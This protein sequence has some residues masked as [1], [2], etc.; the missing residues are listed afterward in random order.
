MGQE[1][2]TLQRELQSEPV[3]TPEQI[4]ILA[5]SIIDERSRA[6]F[7]VVYLTAGRI[8]EVVALEEPQIKSIDIG[9]VPILLFENMRNEK[10]QR[11]Q[12][13]T[14]PVRTDECPFLCQ[15]I[16]SYLVTRK[17]K[18][19]F[20]FYTTRRA[21]QLLVDA[22]GI[23]PHYIRHIRLTHLA[24]RLTPYQLLK[25]AGWTDISMV[26]RYIEFRWQDLI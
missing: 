21:N 7:A 6:L 20:D 25:F 4:E 13:K 14:L 15:C 16:S 9:G 17:G 8:G 10:N 22:V 3:P 12:F 5:K 1:A 24:Q 18:R 11:K 23:N 26:D 2:W 19:L